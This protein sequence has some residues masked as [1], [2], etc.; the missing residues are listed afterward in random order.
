MPDIPLDAQAFDL[1]F[2][3]SRPTVYAGLL[4]GLV[5][6]V[7]YDHAGHYEPAFSLKLSNKSIRAITLSQDGSHLYAGGKGKALLHVTF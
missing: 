1:A 5:Q 7:S 4:S 2:H 3:P 6:A